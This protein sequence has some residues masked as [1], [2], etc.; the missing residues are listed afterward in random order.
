[1]HENAF[2]FCTRNNDIC[3]KKEMAKIAFLNR[4]KLKLSTQVIEYC[5]YNAI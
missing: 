5:V 4:N 2:F 3:Q 1:M